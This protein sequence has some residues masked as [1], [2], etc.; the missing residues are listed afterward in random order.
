MMNQFRANHLATIS[1]VKQKK[2]HNKPKLF[3]KDT[4]AIC[5]QSM[6][7]RRTKRTK[8]ET[9]RKNKRNKKKFKFNL[10]IELESNLTSLY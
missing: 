6:K 3:S 8:K 5:R 10:L 9:K 7:Y 1:C 2:Y 4:S